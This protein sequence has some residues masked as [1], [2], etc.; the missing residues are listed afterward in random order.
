MALV[1]LGAPVKTVNIVCNKKQKREL[2]VILF[3]DPHTFYFFIR[4]VEFSM[5]LVRHVP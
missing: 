4:I 2:M 5:Y 1:P 3:K